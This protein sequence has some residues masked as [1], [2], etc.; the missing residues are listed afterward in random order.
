MIGEAAEEYD[1]KIGFP[2]NA[3]IDGTEVAP[4]V[5]TRESLGQSRATPTKDIFKWIRDWNKA[6]GSGIFEPV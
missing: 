6:V 5:G 2:E 1:S 4:R 3:D